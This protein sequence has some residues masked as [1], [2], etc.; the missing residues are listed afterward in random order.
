[1]WC[2][3][4]KYDSFTRKWI[5]K[6]IALFSVCHRVSESEEIFWNQSFVK[7]ELPKLKKCD[8]FSAPL[9]CE[10]LQR[11]RTKRALGHGL[12]YGLPV[13]DFLRTSLSIVLNLCKQRAPSISHTYDSLL[14]SILSVSHSNLFK[15]TRGTLESGK[16]ECRVNTTFGQLS[17]ERVII[18]QSP[19]WS[20]PRNEP[21]PWNDPQIDP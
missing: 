18:A 4:C 21:Q 6:Y 12:H 16:Q 15:Q 17:Y 13:V 2:V 3:R 10:R 14:S 19:K 20:R 5:G 8:L 1:M 7:K 9:G 11:K